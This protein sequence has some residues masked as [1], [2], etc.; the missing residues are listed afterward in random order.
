MNAIH[1]P[2]QINR[3][4]LRS[5]D[6]VSFSAETPELTDEQ[7][8]AFRGLAKSLAYAIIE[9]ENGSQTVL[10]V[11]K[12]VSGKTPSQRLR[13]VLFV[14]WKQ[15]GEPHNDFEVYYRIMMNKYIDDVKSKLD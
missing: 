11:E 1:T 12:D 3:V 2:L 6:S 15:Q 8:L 5:D 4:S 10:K 14:Q 7:L 9:P 13:G